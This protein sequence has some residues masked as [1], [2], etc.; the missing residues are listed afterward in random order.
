MLMKMSGSG[1][2]GAS[3]WENR[4]VAATGRRQ[5]CVRWRLISQL[6][7]PAWLGSQRLS[8]RACDQRRS[9]D[10]QHFGPSSATAILSKSRICGF[11]FW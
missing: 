1:K 11:C 4:P 7:A 10:S 6:A 5:L 3:A 2:A 9:A 8:L